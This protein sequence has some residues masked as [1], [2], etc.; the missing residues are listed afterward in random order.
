MMSVQQRIH[1]VWLPPKLSLSFVTP[2]YNNLSV[3]IVE[4]KDIYRYH[5]HLMVAINEAFRDKE[6]DIR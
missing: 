5:Q 6:R 4:N 2:P 1:E 3:C